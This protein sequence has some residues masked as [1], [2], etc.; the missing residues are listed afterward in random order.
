MISIVKNHFLVYDKD[1]IHRCTFLVTSEQLVKV[2]DL[3]D[4]TALGIFGQREQRRGR[5]KEG[6]S[7]IKRE[8]EKCEMKEEG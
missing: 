5:G 6:R 4:V 2:T 8:R 3:I 7:K 1:M